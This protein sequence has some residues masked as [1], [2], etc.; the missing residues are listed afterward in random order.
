MAAKKRIETDLSEAERDQ[1]AELL[2][3]L[4]GAQVGMGPQSGRYDGVVVGEL[5]AMIDDG[6]TPLVIF[7]GQPGSAAIRARS[8]VDLHGAHIGRHVVLIFERGDPAMPIVLGVLREADAHPIM[9]GSAQPTVEADDERLV[10]TATR[11]LTLRCGEA[12]ITLTR[13]GKVVI[14]GTFVS[15]RSSGVNRI[16][17][18]SVQI[19]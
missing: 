14:Q 18:G 12:S 19:N 2:R 16:V 4:L 9:G 6:L 7:P 10:V 11:Q 15:S 8:V 17:G 1:A 5:I 3:P 13:E